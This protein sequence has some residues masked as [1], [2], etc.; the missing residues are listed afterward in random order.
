MN[1]RPFP[2]AVAAFYG[3]LGGRRPSGSIANWNISKTSYLWYLTE[4][5]ITV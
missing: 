5:T 3:C 4:R 1:D 2:R